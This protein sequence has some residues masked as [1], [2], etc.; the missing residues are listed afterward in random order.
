MME[1]GHRKATDPL[2]FSGLKIDSVD[3]DTGDIELSLEITEYMIN[4]NGTLHGGIGYTLSDL[5]AG[6]SAYYLGYKVSTM[7][8]NINY[9]RPAISGTLVAKGKVIHNGRTSFVIHV[10]VLSDEGKLITNSTFTMAKLEK[11]KYH[12]DNR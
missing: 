1:E 10:E 12:K 8:A 9:V 4:P 6:L 2:I 7:Q 5:C 3:M 11:N